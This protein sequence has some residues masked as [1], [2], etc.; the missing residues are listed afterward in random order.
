MYS[1][2]LTNRTFPTHG[3]PSRRSHGH[4]SMSPFPIPTSVADHPSATP[5]SQVQQSQ[6]PPKQLCSS[7]W[8]GSYRLERTA[9]LQTLAVELSRTGQGI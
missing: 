2:N 1:R 5:H 9:T 4:R 8:T 6:A 3:V 7:W